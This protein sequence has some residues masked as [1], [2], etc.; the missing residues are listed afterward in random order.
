VTPWE[1]TEKPLKIKTG[2][3]VTLVIAA[4]I[5]VFVILIAVS[6]QRSRSPQSAGTAGG[7]A[8]AGAAPAGAAQGGATGGRQGA[9]G[10][11]AVAAAG[12]AAGGRQGAASRNAT[13]V[14]VTP[15]QPDTIETT[16]ILNGDVL[17]DSLQVSLVATIPSV[18]P[19]AKLLETRFKLGDTV[20]QG[21]TVAIVDPSRPG[22]SFSKISVISTASGTVIQ[23]PP[24][25]L[26][27][28]I[29]SSTAIYVLRDLS[30][31]VLETYLPERYALSAKKGLTA[32]VRLGAIADETFAAVVDEVS[33]TL[34]AA[35]RTLKIRLRF[36]KP[37]PRIQAGMFASVSLV[38]NTRSNVPVIPR[39]ALINTYGTWVVFAV[40]ERDIA[41]RRE[42][43][44]GLESETV[45]EV[46][47]GLAVGERVVSAGQNFLSDGDT[48][49]VVQ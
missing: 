18:V 26:G 40:D 12:G 4:V 5:V 13:I 25:V 48:V 38:T 24:V 3:I 36:A 43:E 16:V 34:D 22:T 44:L 45:V 47:A 7:A 8:P 30:D 2:A 41:H 23:G 29:T 32:Q 17:L 9:A 49:R 19:N 28:T 20:K 14:R 27:D 6:F 33:P 11:A 21:D 39:V 37:D 1:K 35:S 46:T 15:V 10:A 42:I 31:L